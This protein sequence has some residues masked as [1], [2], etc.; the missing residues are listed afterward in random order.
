MAVRVNPADGPYRC[1]PSIRPAVT[2]P[3]PPR[4]FAAMAPRRLLRLYDECEHPAMSVLLVA[5]AGGHLKQLHE[6]LPRFGCD[7]QE[8]TWV[9]FDNAQSR[10]L[11][12]GEHVIYATYPEPRDIADTLRNTRLAFRVLRRG[13]FDVAISTGSSIALAFLP[14]AG[15]FGTSAH[16]VES[17]TRVSG[18]SM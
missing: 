8:R 13:R 14:L 2:V 11:L 16:Y 3:E 5:G 12:A 1:P 15:R 6:L 10:S 9:T 17:A 18:A 4:R 7:G